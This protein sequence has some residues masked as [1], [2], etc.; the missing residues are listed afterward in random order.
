MLSGS[1]IVESAEQ[2]ENALSP[3]LVTPL[4]ITTVVSDEQ[5]ENALSAIL[6]M[7]SGTKYIGS[8]LL[9]RY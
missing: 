8:V 6:V 1:L 9:I 2:P 4:R 7:L 5:P 3:M